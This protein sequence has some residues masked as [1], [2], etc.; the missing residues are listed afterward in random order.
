MIEINVVQKEAKSVDEVE[1]MVVDKVGITTTIIP[2]TTTRKEKDQQE[3]IE[4]AI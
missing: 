4:E 2:T 1:V 3:V